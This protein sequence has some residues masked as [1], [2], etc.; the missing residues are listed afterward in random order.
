MSDSHDLLAELSWRGL[1]QERSDGLEARLARGPIT[2][3]VGFDPTAPSLHAGNLVPTMDL[4][5]LQ[6]AGGRPVVVVGGGTGM[7]G[8]PSGTSAERNLLDDATLD[9]NLAGIRAQ[10]ERFLDF[11]ESGGRGARVVDNREWLA[12]Y[13]LIGYL[14]DIG[15]HFGVSYMLAKESVQQRLATGVSFTEFSYMTLQAADFLELRRRYGVELQMGG[16]DQWGNIT[17]GMELIRRVEGR[18]EG[19]EPL[20][21]GL[22]SPLLLDS[23]GAKF[24]KTAKGAVWLSAELTS[25][26]EFFQYW[27]NREDADAGTYLRRLTLMERER[28]ETLEAEQAERPGDRPAQRALAYDITARVHG[29]AEA[30][31][32][33]R[34]AAAVFSGEPLR[35]PVLLDELYQ[36]LDRFEFGE[37]E[38]AGDVVSLSVASGLYASKGEAR[39][40]IQQGA[41]SIDGERVTDPA[42]RVPEPV[43]APYLV[44]RSGRRHIRVGRRRAD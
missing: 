19:A 10:L 2:G 22:A 39:R 44:L 7:I 14:R 13:S 16:A 40:S 15:K 29:D 26:Y 35:D 43:S 9:R 1:V 37:G 17:A 20:A 32:Q 30:A 11:S 31:R 36:A 18:A 6:R 41:L 5:H 34:V 12:Q 8:D 4:L 24:G 38:L 23:S 3:Y 25:P 28:I 33:L 21:Y 27:L 42:A